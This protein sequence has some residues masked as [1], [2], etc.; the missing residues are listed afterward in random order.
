MLQCLYSAEGMLNARAGPQHTLPMG[1]G[2]GQ[3]EGAGP[4]GQQPL[5]LG[6]G[7]QHQGGGPGLLGSDGAADA[8]CP[9]V[10]WAEGSPS[11]SC[12]GV[13]AECG[14]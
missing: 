5:P 8:L 12:L 1:F 6:L 2:P 11:Q 4:P 14:V 10:S 13:S 3:A 7:A 9:G